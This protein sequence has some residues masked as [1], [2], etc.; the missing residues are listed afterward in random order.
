MPVCETDVLRANPRAGGTSCPEALPSLGQLIA[1]RVAAGADVGVQAEVKRLPAHGSGNR[2]VACE[3]RLDPGV[4]DLIAQPLPEPSQRLP[5]DL[6]DDRKI[7]LRDGYDGAP[8]LFPR[9][10]LQ[11]AHEARAD[12]LPLVEARLTLRRAGHQVAHRECPVVDLL[13]AREP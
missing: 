5:C 4:R 1:H 2:R 13:E 12:A 9:P 10:F 7:A 3:L 6:V 11:P 8:A